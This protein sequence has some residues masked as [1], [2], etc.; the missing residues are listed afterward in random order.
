M[1]GWNY[2]L[3]V[4][5]CSTGGNVLNI[6]IVTC[7]MTIVTYWQQ[8]NCNATADL[9]LGSIVTVVFYET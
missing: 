4:Y 3:F 1:T 5:T 9:P 8:L 2:M 6:T 7:I